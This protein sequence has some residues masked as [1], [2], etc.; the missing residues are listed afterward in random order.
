MANVLPDYVVMLFLI[1]ALVLPGLVPP[2][3]IL[4]GFAAPAWLMI[5]TLLA[6]GVAVSRRGSCSGSCCCRSSACRPG[7]SPR[8]WSSA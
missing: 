2:A 3:D 5:F 1:L 4:G 6:V 7:S 8:A